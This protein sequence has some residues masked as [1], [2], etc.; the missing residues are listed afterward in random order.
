VWDGADVLGA[1]ARDD[2]RGVSETFTRPPEKADERV[3]ATALQLRDAAVQP[4]VVSDDR[5]HVRADADRC[6]LTWISC[7][8]FEER[9]SKPLRGDPFASN[10]GRHA[11]WALTRLVA[12][13]LV[14]EPGVG[15]DA[16]VADLA[17]ALAYSEVASRKPRKMAKAVVRWLREYGVEVRG[18]PHEHRAL[19]AALFHDAPT[20][21]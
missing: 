19:L 4:V 5:Q 10:A 12:A 2:P 9:L 3:I 1:P 13:G 17:T 8:Q 18:G 20:L 7:E 16:L 11:R 21:R 14:D 15:G 6:G